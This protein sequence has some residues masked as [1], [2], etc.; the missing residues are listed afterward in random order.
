MDDDF[1]V[2]DEFAQ[3]FPAPDQSDPFNEAPKPEKEEDVAE[4]KEKD[5]REARRAKKALQEEREA[6]ILMA[7]RLRVLSEEVS[8]L[9]KFK[10][11]TRESVDSDLHKVLF[12]SQE[13]TP[14]TRATAVNLQ[15]VFERN[16]QLAKEGAIKELESRSQ[17]GTQEF[18]RA[19]D[20]V[21]SE[22]EA[23]ED[24]YGVD[25]TSPSKTRDDFVDFVEKL[26]R[27]DDEGNI[28]EYADFQNA[29]E[30]FQTL[31]KRDSSRQR[32]LGSRGMTRSGNTTQT[33][34]DKAN[35]DYLISIG[36][37]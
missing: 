6:S 16:M 23:L 30:V 7:E 29:Y 9:K 37:L 35:Q 8:E 11:E 28:T 27:K 3:D 10:G 26:S 20:F 17:A 4:V 31:Q 12:G 2:A 25:L 22:F 13:E 36:V 33:V 34:A 21:D 32:D 5:N 18:K 15:K 1:K 19:K 24:K 14:E